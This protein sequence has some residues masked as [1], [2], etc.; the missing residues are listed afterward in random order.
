MKK[1]EAKSKVYDLLI[2]NGYKISTSVKPPSAKGP[3]DAI[4]IQDKL[5]D[6]YFTDKGLDYCYQLRYEGDTLKLITVEV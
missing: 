3:E 5:S 4:S 2:R 6:I 1:S